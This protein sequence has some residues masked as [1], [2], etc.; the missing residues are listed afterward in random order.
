MT[1][2]GARL[3]AI[4]PQLPELSLSTAQTFHVLSDVGNQVARRFGRVYALP[5]EPRAA[6]RSNNKALPG[7]NGEESRELPVPATH[8]IARDGRIVLACIEVEDSKRLGPEAIL[9]ALRP[10][11]AS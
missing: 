4:P 10:L 5:E 7:I 3:V 9:D 1:A 8:G 11:Q 6:L 2:L